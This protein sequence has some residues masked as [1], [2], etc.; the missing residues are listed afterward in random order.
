MNFNMSI[1][2]SRAQKQC[3][4]LDALLPCFLAT[5]LQACLASLLAYWLSVTGLT[6]LRHHVLRTTSNIDH[7]VGAY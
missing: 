2:S 3:P 4:F 1:E 7:P 5:F 6:W